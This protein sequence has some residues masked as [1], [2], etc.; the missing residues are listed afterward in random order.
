M[1]QV[2]LT[3]LW[4]PLVAFAA[5]EIPD[6]SR[7]RE[8]NLAYAAKLPSFVADETA[9]RY[10]SNKSDPPR[11]RLMN[12]VE[13]EIDIHGRGPDSRRNIRLNGKP[14]NK[15]SDPNPTFHWYIGFGQELTS[16]FDPKCSTAIEFEGREEWQG[17]AV[18]AFRYHAPRDGCFGTWNTMPPANPPR[19]WRFLV[20]VPGLNLIRYEE[21]GFDFPAGLERV[22]FT[23]ETSW[24]HVNIGGES[25]VLPVAFEMEVVNG[26][27]VRAVVEYKN[28]RHFEAAADVTFH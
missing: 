4:L 26:G 11:W 14:W 5:D 22:H 16:L 10:T 27:H 18:L 9:K 19:R 20:E 21:E 13:S 17:K 7:V 24:D 1:R 8:V 3:V 15:S 23:I 25:Y 28:H 2:P 6:L 12:T